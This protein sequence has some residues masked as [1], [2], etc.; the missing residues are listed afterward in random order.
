LDRALE[1]AT[2]LAFG[3]QQAIR[4]TEH[5]LN[6]GWLTARCPSI[7]YRAWEFIGLTSADYPEARRAFRAKQPL[8]FPSGSR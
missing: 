6:K 4:G 5:S 1:I 7:N 3:S 8:R 2:N